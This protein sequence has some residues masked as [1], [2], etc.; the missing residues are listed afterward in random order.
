[1]DDTGSP[2]WMASIDQ[3]RAYSCETCNGSSSECESDSARATAQE[4][5]RKLEKA[6]E[7][8]SDVEGPA[9][10]ALHAE[11]KGSERCFS[12]DIGRADSAVR[13]FHHEVQTVVA[14]DRRATSCRGVVDRSQGQR[15][16]M[17]AEPP[18]LPDWEA[19]V[20]RLLQQMSELQCQ[21]PLYSRV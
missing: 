7:V 9:V 19:E 13:I 12:A 4:R 2:G 1:M 10:E 5:A 21:K 11:L 18:V 15:S 3:G 17:I 16:E 6:L 14:R 8:M 20:K